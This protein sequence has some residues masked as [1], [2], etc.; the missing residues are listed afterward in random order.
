MIL[1]A[2]KSLHEYHIWVKSYNRAIRPKD[3]AIGGIIVAH[4]TVPKNL[5]CLLNRVA[6][7]AKNKI[8]ADSPPKN[9][10]TDIGQCHNSR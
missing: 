8:P 9:K 5:S 4:F 2:V 7:A 10:Y 6:R 3:K 1:K